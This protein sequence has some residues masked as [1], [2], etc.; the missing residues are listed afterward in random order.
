MLLHDSKCGAEGVLVILKGILPSL[1]VF[2]F[3]SSLFRLFSDK[4][5][6]FSSHIADNFLT[7][8][9]TCKAVDEAALDDLFCDDANEI[10][11][12]VLFN[13]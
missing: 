6:V 7:Q 10:F 13:G 9:F 12:F 4:F 2:P 3:T 5:D 1:E 8:C 11:Q